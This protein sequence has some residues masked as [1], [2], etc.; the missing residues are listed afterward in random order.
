MADMP[1]RRLATAGDIAQAVACWA[2]S[3]GASRPSDYAGLASRY[4]EA[5]I[6]VSSSTEVWSVR[7]SSVMRPLRRRFT[8]SHISNTWT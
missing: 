7:L 3:C 5:T 2:R 4:S 8:R 1:L 6:D